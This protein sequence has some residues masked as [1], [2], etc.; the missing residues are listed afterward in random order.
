MNVSIADD[1]CLAFK[2]YLQNPEN[3][4]LDELLPCADLASSSTQY[5]QVREAMKSVITSATEQFLYYANGSSGLIG[6]CDPIGPPP[7]YTYTGICEND[8]LPIGELS[9]I[10]KPFVCNQTQDACLATGVPFYV[11]QST[12]DGIVAISQASQ[13]TLD[14][15]P[16]ME[17]LTNCSLVKD[18][19]ST[20]V[21]VRCGPA[22]LAI[23]RIW[24]CFAVLSSIM[25]LLIIFWCVANRRN[26]QQRYVTTIMPQEQSFNVQQPFHLMEK[27][28]VSL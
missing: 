23:N 17:S 5:L 20:M 11:N 1:T 27:D 22:K 4:T 2:Q 9:N 18:P 25:V 10:V 28:H 3:T 15:F 26:I 19:I 24:I 13:G 8:T 16:V 12:Y 7:D 21:R 14:A 6:V